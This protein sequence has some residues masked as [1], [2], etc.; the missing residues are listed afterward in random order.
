VAAGTPTELANAPHS[1]TAPYLARVLAEMSGG[2]DGRRVAVS[3]QLRRR[4]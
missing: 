4:R 2:P 1:R 3:G